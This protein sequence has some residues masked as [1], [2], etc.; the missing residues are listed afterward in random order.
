MQTMRGSG[1]VYIVLHINKNT[2][3]EGGSYSI[4]V[5]RYIV[6]NTK[7]E[8]GIYVDAYI[9]KYKECRYTQKHMG[10]CIAYMFIYV[11]KH[12]KK[13]RWCIACLFI[14]I[15]QTTKHEICSMI[16]ACTYH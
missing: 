6:K 2:N 15:D 9:G 16:V 14:H 3:N 11:F 1:I 12:T 5:Y 13:L 8:R 7:N 10:C 4:Y